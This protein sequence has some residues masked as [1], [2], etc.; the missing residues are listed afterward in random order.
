[1]SCAAEMEG[2]TEVSHVLALGLDLWIPCLK[3]RAEDIP[4]SNK[5]I[6]RAQPSPYL[7]KA[8]SASW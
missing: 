3:A 2:H 5:F 7:H 4:G 6:A 1:M 8:L